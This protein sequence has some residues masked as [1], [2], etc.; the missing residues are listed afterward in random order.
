MRRSVVLSL[1]FQ[2]VFPASSIVQGANLIKPFWCKFTLF[3][4]KLHNFI[5]LHP[6]SKETKM[7]QLTKRISKLTPNFFMGSAPGTE[8]LPRTTLQLIWTSLV[9]TSV[10]KKK[11]FK[12]L[13]PGFNSI[14]SFGKPTTK[15]LFFKIN[16]TV[17]CEKIYLQ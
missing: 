11:S 8:G 1:P 9:L 6:F 10:T 7:V 4:Y 15:H 16:F 3:L 2:L 12:M 14:S 5:N 13:I 17:A